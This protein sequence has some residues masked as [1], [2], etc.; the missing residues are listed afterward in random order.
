MATGAHTRA[1]ILPEHTETQCMVVPCMAPPGCMADMAVI[2]VNILPLC[3]ADQ[4][5]EVTGASTAR[6]CTVARPTAALIIEGMG[7]VMVVG[8]A[9]VACTEGN[10]GS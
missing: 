3:T 7:W 10:Q 6:I 8:M 5:M 9:Q 1:R 4:V 2:R